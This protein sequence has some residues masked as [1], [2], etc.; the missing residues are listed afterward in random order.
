MC[1]MTHFLNGDGLP[2]LSLSNE[3]Q[4]NLN[5]YAAIVKAGSSHPSDDPF[6]SVVVC[7]H[8]TGRKPCGSYLVVAHRADDVIHWQCP[9]C[10]E[11]GFIGNWRGTICDYSGAIE[12]DPTERVSVLVTP[13]EHKLLSG[14]ITSSQEEDAIICGAVSTPDGVI[15]SG[16]LDDFDQLMGSI[17]FDAN[18]CSSLKHQRAMDKI[19]AKIETVVEG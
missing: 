10:G 16:G 12:S 4:S 15:M 7:R 18:H 5:Y 9:R 6:S 2:P 17:A 14:I 19:R 11:Q 1:D 13:E 8:E 3:L